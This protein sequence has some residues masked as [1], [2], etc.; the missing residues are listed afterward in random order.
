[1]AEDL[2]KHSESFSPT[3]ARGATTDPGSTSDE[4]K[5]PRLS[6]ASDDGELDRI[7]VRI[8]NVMHNYIRTVLL[9]ATG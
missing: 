7:A 4:D 3:S 1:M 8:T 2:A 9:L 5:K 6:S